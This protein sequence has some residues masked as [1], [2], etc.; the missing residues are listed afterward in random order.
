MGH[1]DRVQCPQCKKFYTPELISPPGPGFHPTAEPY[2]KEQLIIGIC[3]DKCYD[4][5][6]SGHRPEYTYD[7]KGRRFENGERKPFADPPED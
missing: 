6:I 7:E 2:Q 5:S 4:E 1:R 3:S